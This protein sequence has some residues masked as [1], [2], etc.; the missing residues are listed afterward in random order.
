[1][2]LIASEI[3]ALLLE[4]AHLLDTSEIKRQKWRSEFIWN[5]KKA[6]VDYPDVDFL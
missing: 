5:E 2:Q 1:M 3:R 4:R 6:P